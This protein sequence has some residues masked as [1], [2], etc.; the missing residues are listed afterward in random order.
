MKNKPNVRWVVLIL[1]IIITIVL[2]LF[3]PNSNDEKWL[4]LIIPIATGMFAFLLFYDD[5]FGHGG[6]A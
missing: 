1:S 5:D 6:Y 2:L 3:I 4:V